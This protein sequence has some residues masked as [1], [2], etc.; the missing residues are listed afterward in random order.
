[1]S[2]D[3]FNHDNTKR[4]FVRWRAAIIPKHHTEAIEGKVIEANFDTL[5]MLSAT[6]L[7]P[8]SEARFMLEV[9]EYEGASSNKNTLDL[10]G[11]IIDNALIGHI[12]LFRHQI[13]LQTPNHTQLQLLKKLTA[14]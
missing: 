13:Q 10:N 11:K 7:K 4:K 3:V 1:M 5:I 2:Q 6:A 8:G 12:S 9:F 14:R